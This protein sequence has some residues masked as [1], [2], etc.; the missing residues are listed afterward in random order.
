MALILATLFFYTYNG[1]IIFLGFVYF[2]PAAIIHLIG[3]RWT[4]LLASLLSLFFSVFLLLIWAISQAY[5]PEPYD[6]HNNYASLYENR[7]RIESITGISI[8]EF[9]VDSSK[10]THI[11]QFD[12][13]FTTE[14]DLTFKT[15]PDAKT[16]RYLDSLCE[17]YT[18]P[19]VDTTVTGPQQPEPVN[20]YWSKEKDTYHFSLYG[21][22]EDKK[23]HSED[24]FFSLTIKKNSRIAEMRYGNY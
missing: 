8:P 14:A 3:K 19:S 9:T 13:E 16:F 15:L 22:T 5:F 12:F 1:W 2:V 10:I 17:L 24:A 18:P 21:N 7:E 6:V 20:I 23:L 11:S 4:G